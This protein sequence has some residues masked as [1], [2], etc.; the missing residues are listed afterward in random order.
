MNRSSKKNRDNSDNGREKRKRKK[1]MLLCNGSHMK[2]YQK[3][4]VHADTQTNNSLTFD[5][6]HVYEE[7]KEKRCAD[8]HKQKHLQ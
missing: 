8:K 1:K 6:P 7:K 4:T 2:R 3:I 5:E